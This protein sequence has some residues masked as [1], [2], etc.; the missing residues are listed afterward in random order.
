MISTAQRPHV[1]ARCLPAAC[2]V[3]VF[4]LLEKL[5]KLLRLCE[6]PM[7]SVLGVLMRETK[8]LWRRAIVRQ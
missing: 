6:V 2:H 4:G 5:V 7:G 1:S 8:L 3:T